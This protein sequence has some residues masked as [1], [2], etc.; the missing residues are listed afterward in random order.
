[1]AT[2][3]TRWLASSSCDCAKKKEGGKSVDD[4]QRALE[5]APMRTSRRHHERRFLF[6]HLCMNEIDALYLMTKAERSPPR[7]GQSGRARELAILA[8]LS[9]LASGFSDV[10]F[11]K[12]SE[13]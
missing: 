11:F 7:K 12:Q 2:M 13:S 8:T 5:S 6:L 4:R 1:M 3:E 9:M 10:P